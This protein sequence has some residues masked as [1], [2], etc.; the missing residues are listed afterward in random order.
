M[1]LFSAFPVKRMIKLVMSFMQITIRIIYDLLIRSRAHVF[2]TFA[3]SVSEA[4][5]DG[6][7][8]EQEIP[9]GKCLFSINRPLMK[10]YIYKRINAKFSNIQHFC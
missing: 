2:E 6:H 1:Q 9:K 10:L 4:S 7:K 8:E 5:H 3:T